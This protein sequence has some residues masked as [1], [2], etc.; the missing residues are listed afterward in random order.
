[1]SADQEFSLPGW[2]WGTN[3]PGAT[4]YAGRVHIVHPDRPG[5][6]LCG[7]PV[8]DLWDSH[9]ST[10]EHLCPTCGVRAMDTMY[11]PVDPSLI[12]GRHRPGH[13]DHPGGRQDDPAEQTSVLPV[14]RDDGDP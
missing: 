13:H 1:M 4:F 10:P 11:R 9:P 8:E 5:N 6:T 3:P 2:W 12:T 14:V 7:L